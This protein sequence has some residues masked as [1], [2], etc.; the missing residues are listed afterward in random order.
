MMTRVRISFLFDAA[1]Y[2]IVCIYYILLIYS[3]VDGHLDCFHFFTVVTNAA[4]NIGV[5]TSVLSLLSLLL[6]VC[7]G[8][9][10][11]G[12]G[13]QSFFFFNWRLITLQYWSGF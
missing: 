11:P 7:P 13:Y 10:L 1:Y 9:E 12:R 5:Q 8:V 6:D 4:L 2:C 3:H